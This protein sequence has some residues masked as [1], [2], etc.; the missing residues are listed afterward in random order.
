MGSIAIMACCRVTILHQ[1][2]LLR[3]K[4]TRQMR[5]AV[6]ATLVSNLY[7]AERSEVRKTKG[8][9]EDCYTCPVKGRFRIKKYKCDLPSLV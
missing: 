9:K 7:L 3:H 8:G 4:V 2:P 6:R 5:V 1:T